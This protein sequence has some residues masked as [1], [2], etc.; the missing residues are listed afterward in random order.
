MFKKDSDPNLKFEIFKRLN[1]GAVSLNHQELRNCIY[2]GSY[3]ALI[4]ELATE[5]DFKYLFGLNA[6]EKRMRDVELVLRFL[7]FYNATYLNYKPPIK[8]FLNADMRTHSNITKP[9]M[10]KLRTAFKNA[11]Q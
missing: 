7:S 2:R 5:T 6:P 10:D 8:D 4:K 3:N 9:E 1:T 11:F